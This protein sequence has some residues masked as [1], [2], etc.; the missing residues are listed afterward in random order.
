MALVKCKEC[1]KEMSDH[2]GKC[3]H[4]GAGKFS[5][6]GVQNPG[7]L[8]VLGFFIFFVGAVMF[9]FALNY[10]GKYDVNSLI[11]WGSL[12][13]VG[14]LGLMFHKWEKK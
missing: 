6:V 2:A 14:G 10:L 12:L 8:R 4:C 11:T 7:G 9:F 5:S 1:G 3:P 13:A